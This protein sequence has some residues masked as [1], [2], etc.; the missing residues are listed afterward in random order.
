MTTQQSIAIQ[1]I[2]DQH[3]AQRF[4]AEQAGREQAQLIEESVIIAVEVKIKEGRMAEARQIW[5]DYKKGK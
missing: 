5:I 2:N 1:R 4:I 3:E